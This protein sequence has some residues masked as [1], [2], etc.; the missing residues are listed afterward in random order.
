MRKIAKSMLGV[1]VFVAVTVTASCWWLAGVLT[2]PRPAPVSMPA[3]LAL[4]TVTLQ[5]SDGIRIAGS[6]LPP[7]N[8]QAGCMLL[9]HGNGRNRSQ[10]ISQL[11]MLQSAGHGALAI[12]FRGHGQ[13]GG[14]LATAGG[15]EALDANV[16]F[17]ALKLHCGARKI[18]IYGFSLGG[19]A[20]LQGYAAAKADGLILDAVYQNITLAVAVRLQYAFGEFPARLL[21]PILLEMLKL[22]TGLD[23]EKMDNAMHARRVMSPMLML[24]GAADWQAPTSQMAAIASASSSKSVQT[25]LVPQ[26][27][28]GGNAHYLGSRY[29]P[30]LLEFLSQITA[31]S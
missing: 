12:D 29:Q 16:A 13:S 21:T 22:R 27:T 10:F 26:S 31:A 15:F 1:L 20:A 23:P 7:R 17:D 18:V 9:L 11:A 4:Q 19:A 25:I 6:Y 14:K 3:R 8:A 28:H 24:A 5:T 30:L 2:K